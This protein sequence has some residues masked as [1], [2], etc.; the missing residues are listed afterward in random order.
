MKELSIADIKVVPEFAKVPDEQLQWLIDKGEAIEMEEGD[1]LFN[2][3][4]PVT[5]TFIVLDGKIRIC[6]TQSGQLREIASIEKGGVTGYLPF[7]RAIKAFAYCECVKP[8]WIFVCSADSIRQGIS[9]YYELTE[10]LVHMMSTRVRETT[11]TLQQNEKMFALGKLSA[12]LAHELNNP[13]AA[14]SRA[15]SLLQSQVRQLPHLFKTVSGL[16]VDQDKIEKIQQLVRDK[17]NSTRPVLNM[18]QKA[19]QEDKLT[20]WLEDHNID[21]IDTEGLTDLN[22]TVNDLEIIKDCL[23][24]D[25]L[26]V[27]LEWIGNFLVTNKMADDIRISSER[28]SELVGAVKNFTFMDKASDKQMIDIHTGIRNTLTIL[29]YKLKNANIT[30]VENYDETIPKIKAFPGDLN[31]VWTNLIDNAID[32]MEV[33]KKGALEI[34]T[35]R[36]GRFVKVV[37]KDDGPGIAKD[38]QQKI[39]D[40]FFT[41][42]EM[43]KGTGL[44]LDVVNRIIRQ[45]NGSVKVN[46][47]P[48]ATGFE[49]CLPMNE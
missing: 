38:I 2:E 45:H 14:I 48:G 27:V 13:A 18:L 21:N 42:K 8:S 28:I 6:T 35:T 43:G 29:N 31:Q 15:A 36:D 12:G 24:K 7:S 41:T 46:S 34:S 32:A 4:D 37:L 3:G 9:Q 1:M 22:F 11:A 16:H 47:Q 33:N 30:V 26:V 25:E 23:T 39:F 5:K 44:G 19:E 17:I 10:A 20:S 40:P 49:V